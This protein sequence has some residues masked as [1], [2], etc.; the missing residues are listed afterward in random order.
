MLPRVRA[1]AQA[2]IQWA[3]APYLLLQGHAVRASY[4][5]ASSE[6]TVQAAM[7]SCHPVCMKKRCVAASSLSRIPYVSIFQIL[8]GP[9][10]YC[11]ARAT[12]PG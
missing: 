3:A 6:R 4:D 9:V 12:L 10:P 2:G 11:N 7:P 5:T 8:H 1:Y